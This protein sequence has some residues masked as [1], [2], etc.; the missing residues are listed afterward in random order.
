MKLIRLTR[1]LHGLHKNNAVGTYEIIM[2][3]NNSR[4]QYFD[5]GKCLFDQLLHS[6]Q[7]SAI[8][9]ELHGEPASTYTPCCGQVEGEGKL[10][11]NGIFEFNRLL[12]LRERVQGQRC[13]ATVVSRTIS[14]LSLIFNSRERVLFNHLV[15]TGSSVGVV[16]HEGAAASS[17]GR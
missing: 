16:G 6:L 13:L 11:P 5:V 1:L 12:F 7:A 3:L 2:A 9:V 8:I 15:S 17:D 14:H 4:P 10:P